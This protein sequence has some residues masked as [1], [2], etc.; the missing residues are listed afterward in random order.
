MPPCPTWFVNLI[1]IASEERINPQKCSF[2]NVENTH[3]IWR[4]WHEFCYG[5]PDAFRRAGSAN[6]AGNV[7]LIVVPPEWLSISR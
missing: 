2:A 3:S 7:A 6:S 4:F 1:F 5:A